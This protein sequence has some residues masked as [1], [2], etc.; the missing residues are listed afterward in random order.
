MEFV[1]NLV[2][3][4]IKNTFANRNQKDICDI[5]KEIESDKKKE[6]KCV[7]RRMSLAQGDH[8]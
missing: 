5:V 4:F 6:N 1:N 8:R 7:K 2:F 3:F